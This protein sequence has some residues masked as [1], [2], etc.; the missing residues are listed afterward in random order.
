[1]PYCQINGLCPFVKKEEENEKT[2]RKQQRSSTFNLKVNGKIKQINVRVIS[3]ESQAEVEYKRKKGSNSLVGK[4]CRYSLRPR[5]SIL[6]WNL[7]LALRNLV[8]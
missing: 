5:K 4:K 8:H 7:V 3:D 1:M 2:K 6:D